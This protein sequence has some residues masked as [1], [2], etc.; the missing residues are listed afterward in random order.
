MSDIRPLTFSAA[1]KVE[2]RSSLSGVVLLEALLRGSSGPAKLC[3][4]SNESFTCT[5]LDSQKVG[6]DHELLY[7]C[8]SSVVRLGM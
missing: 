1:G 7:G 3:G 2:P 4:H 6:W 8:S 5:A